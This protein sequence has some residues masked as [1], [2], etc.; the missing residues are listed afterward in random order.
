MI[1]ALETPTH[2]S[3]DAGL[4]VAWR[5]DVDPLP[6]PDRGFVS[7]GQIVTAL[8][9]ALVR[10]CAAADRRPDRNPDTEGREPVG[11]KGVG[12]SHDT[13]PQNRSAWM[14]KTPPIRST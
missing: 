14:N 4:S 5:T 3:G 8:V 1:S 7:V 10:Q 13:Q 9:A 6:R 12:E 2:P 11:D